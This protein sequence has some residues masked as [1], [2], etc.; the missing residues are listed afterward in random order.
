[1]R[2]ID[3]VLQFRERRGNITEK[4]CLALRAVV[5]SIERGM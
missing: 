3:S 1:V 2:V 4:Q 5:V